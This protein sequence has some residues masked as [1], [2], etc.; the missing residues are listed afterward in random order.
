MD[1]F[2][3]EYEVTISPTERGLYSPFNTSSENNDSLVEEGCIGKT[4]VSSSRVRDW[5]GRDSD[6][7]KSQ[8]ETALTVQS[9][10][11]D[12]NPIVTGNI[13]VIKKRVIGHG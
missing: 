13:T 8:Q 6:D 11:Q 5:T 12:K 2:E 10:V 7:E 4:T 3:T 9:E 1:I